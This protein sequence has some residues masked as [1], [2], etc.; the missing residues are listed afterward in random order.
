MTFKGE[1]GEGGRILVNE[2]SCTEPLVQKAERKKYHAVTH[3]PRTEKFQ[4]RKW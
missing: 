2:K 1:V 4:Y 3:V